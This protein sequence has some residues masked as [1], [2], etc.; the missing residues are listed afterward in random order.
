MRALA[1][2]VL[3]VLAACREAPEPPA[4]EPVGAARVEAERAACERGGGSLQAAAGSRLACVRPMRDAGKQC[5]AAGDCEG[6]CLARS[7][8]CAPFAPLFGCH[9]VLTP[10]GARV[11]ECLD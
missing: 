4:L 7:M 2:P 8:T 9:E 6:A 3:L 1:L 10:T 5:R 11:T